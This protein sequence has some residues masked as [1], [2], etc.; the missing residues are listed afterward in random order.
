LLD[1]T[2]P[3]V[4]ATS[5]GAINIG[6]ATM[7][8]MG[9][10]PRAI[11]AT[12]PTAMLVATGPARLG[13]Q[14]SNGYNFEG[15]LDVGANPVTL[16]GPPGTPTVTGL[17]LNGGTVTGSPELKVAPVTGYIFG[18]GQVT[19]TV[20]LGEDPVPAAGLFGMGSG[21]EL[22]LT[23]YVTG[24]ADAYIDV[25]F[26]G[27]PSLGFSPAYTIG[28]GLNFPTM[29]EFVIGGNAPGEAV[30]DPD[31][32]YDVGVA[33]DYSQY[34]V[35]GNVVGSGGDPKASFFDHPV[36]ELDEDKPEFGW[37]DLGP[38]DLVLIHASPARIRYFGGFPPSWRTDDFDAGVIE[39]GGDFES[40]LLAQLTS[41]EGQLADG[42]SFAPP[43][44]G[45]DALIIKIVPEPGTLVLLISGV[46]GV[47]L[48]WR[49]RR[50]S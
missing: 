38:G 26:S 34:H 6:A 23:G 22:E 40:E 35:A 5:T 7:N 32:D 10:V 1:V 25:I 9:A 13:D 41:I 45:P 20:R 16:L 17:W 36:L 11:N 31:K 30:Y 44:I 29:T 24:K 12:D 4:L 47:L 42:L 2:G 46:L 39:Y 28:S 49:R 15:T 21:S 43:Y 19:G 3:Y 27:A 37:D 33:G 48:V 8:V 18:Q 50:R 14:G